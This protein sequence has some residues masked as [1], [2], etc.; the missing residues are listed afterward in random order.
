MKPTSTD[1]TPRAAR[2]LRWL[3]SALVLAALVLL[4]PHLTS[5]TELVRLRNALVLGPDLDA[6]ATDWQPPQVPAGYMVERV[7]PAPDFVAVARQLGL[8]G[9]AD[10]W[11]RALAITAHLRGSAPALRGDPLRS[12]LQGTYRGIVR[13]GHGYCGD[14]IRAFNAIAVAGGMTVRS[15]AFSFDGYGGHGHIFAE[16]W[17]R[18]QLAWQ[19]VDVFDNYYFVDKS[20]TPLSA[21]GFRQALQRGA[22]GL[23]LRLLHPASGPAFAIESKAWDYFRRGVDQW[24]MPWGLNPFTYDQQPAVKLLV[25]WSRSLEQ[26]AAIV[27]GV[28]PPVRMLADAAS[29]TQRAHM[30]LLSRRLL[31]SGL[32]AAAGLLMLMAS[33]WWRRRAGGS[34]CSQDAADSAWPSVCV[35][36][37]LPPP[38]GGMA[39]QCEQLLRLLKAEGAPVSLVRTNAPYQPRWVGRLPVVR[40]LFRL[41]PY[42]AHLWSGI[43]RA[44]VVHVFANSGWAWHLLAWPALALARLRSVPVIVNYRGGLA[45]EFLTSAPGFVRASLR[46]ATLRVVPS[47]F[48]LG[49][50]AKHQL[51]AEIIPN[52]IDLA[53]FTARTPADFGTAPHLIVTRN[54]EPIYDIA[55]ALKAF[56][57][58]RQQFPQARL[59]VAG[60]GPDLATLQAQARELGVEGAVR[61]AGRIANADIAAL[62]AQADLVLNPSTADNMPISILEALASGVPLV[63]TDAGGIP[64]LVQHERSA[65]MVPVGD[66]PAMAASTVRLLTDRALADTLRA[67]G[68]SDVQRF[69]WKLVREQWRRAYRR[70]ARTT[71]TDTPAPFPSGH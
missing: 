38:S 16:I 54:L 15:W 10:D 56:V 19:L 51:D 67:N 21:L 33:L 26:L 48:L 41:L 42:L 30:H 53:R 11:Q 14:F 13:D 24:Y 23:Q 70:A 71:R 65:L 29:E 2:V 32:A 57:R 7:A 61:F 44:Q 8:A 62:Y 45:D 1:S 18:Q 66:A 27:S 52:I 12:D 4:G 22:P 69:S 60:I 40:A 39:N 37:P 47:R 68:L 64:D 63:T 50:F 17:N 25:G 6:G 46:A 59:T 9:L 28:H 5:D 36:G 58:V 3:G 43:G 31:Q 35:V 20:E 49:V 55:T 34:S